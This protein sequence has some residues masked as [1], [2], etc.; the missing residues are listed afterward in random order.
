MRT[1]YTPTACQH[2]PSAVA[3]GR[4]SREDVG[5]GLMGSDLGLVQDI[6][7]APFPPV[8]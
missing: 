5:N 2:G 4:I 6:I 8:T 1:Q 3:A 7:N